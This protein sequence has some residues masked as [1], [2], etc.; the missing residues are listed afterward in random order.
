MT[1]VQPPGRFGALDLDGDTVIELP[2]KAAGRRRL[3]QR[4]LLRA[5]RRRCSTTSTATR[6]SGSAS[7]WSASP[8]D[9]QL[10]RLSSTTASGSRW[11]RC[12][13]R[14]IS[15]S[16]GR[17][18][19]RRGRSG[20]ERRDFWRGKRVFVTGHTGF[21]GSWLALWLHATG[22]RGHTASRLR[23]RPSR[24]CSTLRDWRRDWR[25]IDHRRR[26]RP[27]A[28]ERG[29]R[30]GRARDRVPL[31]AQSL[32][33]ALLSRAG[34]D[35]RR[36]TS[37]ARS[38][39]SKRSRERRGRRAPSSTSPRD[40]CYENREWVWGYRE[41]DAMGGHD[42]YTSSKGCA[43]LVTAAYRSLVPGRQAGVQLSRA[44]GP[45]TSSAAATGPSD[46]LV[47]D[48]LRALDAGETAD[49]PVSR[50]RRGPGSTCWS[51]SRAT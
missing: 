35:L 9:G 4:R 11:T 51:R 33:R 31:A 45:A 41:N 21:K 25:D 23:R 34:R 49:T 8:H 29:D 40:K 47:P 18:A 16:S 27:A 24:A 2:G 42:P 28:L 46:R 19:R 1:A 15:R 3:D 6:R 10:Q 13:T 36:P 26:P 39:C 12:A 43:E 50:R 48:F 17:R 22:R 37:W 7:R 32:V 14:T 20:S 44:R 38:T 30:R 5:R